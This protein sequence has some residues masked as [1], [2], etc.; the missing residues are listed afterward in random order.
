M[1]KEEFLLRVRA[2]L[3][4]LLAEEIDKEISVL[5]MQISTDDDIKKLGSVDE[6]C[7]K[8]YSSRGIDYAKLH[9][10]TVIHSSFEEMI[11]IVRNLVDQMGK[12]DFKSNI[13]TVFDILLLFVFIALVKVPF[14]AIR[15][16]GDSLFEHFNI[17]YISNIWGLIIELIYIAVA[18]ILFVTI[19]NRYF[20]SFK[21]VE[22]EKAIKGRALESINLSEKKDGE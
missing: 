5:N 10:D 19:F 14:I 4:F 15:S 2:R 17:T 16:L 8:I 9:G 21:D 6:V 3:D 1:K 11:I 13:K 7:K 20:K 22:K 12:N 18:I